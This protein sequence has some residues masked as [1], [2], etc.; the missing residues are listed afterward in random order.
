MKKTLLLSALLGL[1]LLASAQQPATKDTSAAGSQAG[2]LQS[3]TSA[4]L[5]QGRQTDRIHL[6]QRHL[7]YGQDNAIKFSVDGIAD[8]QLI[9]KVVSENLCALR[10]GDKFGEYI[11]TPK[12]EEGM[13]TVRVGYMDVFGAYL[14][15]GN[16]ELFIGAEERSEGC[17]AI[18]DGSAQ[19]ANSQA[20]G[21]ADSLSA[22]SP[23]VVIR[24]TTTTVEEATI[25]Q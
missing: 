10:K 8:N 21:A 25:V 5:G 7:V 14:K 20:T 1:G 18:P 11:L 22:G 4:P 9:V 17:D 2:A 15:V 12:A 23:T 13:V 24:R 3:S 19:R 6:S 16:A